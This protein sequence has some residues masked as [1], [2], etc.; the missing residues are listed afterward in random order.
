MYTKRGLFDSSW[1]QR[2]D[3]IATKGTTL[4]VGDRAPTNAAWALAAVEI[5]GA[6]SGTG[7][8]PPLSYSYDMQGNRT[9]STPA[10]GTP[11]ALTY[12]Q[13]NRL[14][15][16]GTGTTYHYDGDGLRQSKV[17]SGTTTAF[18]WDQSQGLPLILADGSDYYVYGPTGSP[19]EKI[20]G[21][22]VLYLHQDQQGST[23]LLTDSTGSVVG[24]YSYDAYGNTT[25]HTGIAT[26]T[27][28][29]NGQY[30]DAESGYQYLHARYYDPATGIFISVDPLSAIT[31]SRYTYVGNN[32]VNFGD[33]SGLWGWNP[34]SDVAQAG[35][36]LA[37]IAARGSAT[38]VHYSAAGLALDLTSRLSGETV[39]VCVGGGAG[40]GLGV[41]GTLCYVSTPSG[42]TGWQASG[43]GSAGVQYGFNGFVGGTV[44]NAQ[45]LDELNGHGPNLTVG[46]GEG[47]YSG[48]GSYS[49][50]TNPCG[51]TTFQVMAGWTPGLGW[52]VTATAGYGWSAT[53]QSYF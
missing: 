31:S 2:S 43:G 44:S 29:Y 7:G 48:G 32:P 17:V 4:D 40:A 10:G 28:Q 15:G 39:G 25:S 1:V 9:S 49:S 18:V 45:T 27:L 51:H 16:Y 11:T 53:A 21:S 37:P 33:A 5:P 47:P 42:Q 19:I 34:L 13:A 14:I 35:R 50:S 26:T 30:T 46:G 8:G 23:R 3:P 24:T 12:D 36:D 41:G 20:T 6:A 52:P 22:T 38:L